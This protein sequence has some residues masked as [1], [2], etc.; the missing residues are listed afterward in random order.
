VQVLHQTVEEYIKTTTKAK[1]KERKK[2][3]KK[4]KKK[5]HLPHIFLR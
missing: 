3:K 1:E 4:K 5:S 2:K